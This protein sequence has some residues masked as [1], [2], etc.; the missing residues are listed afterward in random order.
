MVQNNTVHDEQSVFHSRFLNHNNHVIML[1]N[2]LTPQNDAAPA[3]TVE[4]AQLI[5]VKNKR[6]KRHAF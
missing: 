6:L 2:E 3:S 4:A 5:K 1:E